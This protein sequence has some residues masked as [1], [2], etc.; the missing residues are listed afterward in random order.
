MIVKT[1]PDKA[2]RTAVAQE[3]SSDGVVSG[4]ARV[5]RSRAAA[6]STEMIMKI[7]ANWKTELPGRMTI[8]TP[9]KPISIASQRR[10]PTFSPNTSAAPSVTT[11]GND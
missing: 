1:T 2:T 7:E 5:A 8:K 10:Q 4:N 6:N 11:N 3:T 9:T